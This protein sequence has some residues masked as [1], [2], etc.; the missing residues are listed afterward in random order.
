[1]MDY[2]TFMRLDW[3][4]GQIQCP[5]HSTASRDMAEADELWMVFNDI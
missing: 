4:T 1:M 3:S 2:F 5:E